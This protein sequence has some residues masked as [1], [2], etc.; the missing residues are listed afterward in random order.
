MANSHVQFKWADAPS[1]DELTDTLAEVG[2]PGSTIKIN[3]SIKDMPHSAIEALLATLGEHDIEAG[4][5]LTC[6]Y[7][8]ARQLT[9]WNMSRQEST[10][11]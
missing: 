11:A 2:Q 6:V 5:T 3:V 9:F 7:E 10:G 8:D 4:L 1:F